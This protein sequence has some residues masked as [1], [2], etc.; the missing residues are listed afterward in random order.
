MLCMALGGV[1]IFRLGRK[2]HKIGNSKIG[3]SI[4]V[5]SRI[6][7]VVCIARCQGNNMLTVKKINGGHNLV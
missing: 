4:G 7:I 3:S 5:S 1:P 2:S 6:G